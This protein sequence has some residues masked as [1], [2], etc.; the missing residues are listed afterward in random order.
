MDTTAALARHGSLS[1]FIPL[2][3]VSARGLSGGERKRVGLAR[4]LVNRPEVIVCDEL[5]AG[6]DDPEPLI[7]VAQAAAP[8][9]LAVTH[10]RELWPRCAGTMMICDGRL[11]FA[12]SLT[13]VSMPTQRFG[14]G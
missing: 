8:L 12:A 10:H 13:D 6:L 11:E 3:I 9:V 2:L 7:R 1:L 5:E 14:S 4:A